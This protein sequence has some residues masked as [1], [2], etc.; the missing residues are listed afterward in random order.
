MKVKLFSNDM[1]AENLMDTIPQG[2]TVGH[3]IDE[4]G[5]QQNSLLTNSPN[6]LSP[7]QFGVNQQDSYCKTIKN[8]KCTEWMGISRWDKAIGSSVS[9][10]GVGGKPWVPWGNDE[11]NPR[12]LSLGNEMVTALVPMVENPNGVFVYS[13]KS[14]PIVAGSIAVDSDGK[15]CKTRNGKRI[16]WADSDASVF[17]DNK[18]P[19]MNNSKP[20][21]LNM[22]MAMRRQQ[23]ARIPGLNFN[24]NYLEVS[25]AVSG[26]NA[27]KL[28]LKDVVLGLNLLDG[29][30]ITPT[31]WGSIA[32]THTLA[33]VNHTKQLF[34]NLPSIISLEAN[35]KLVSE[36]NGLLALCLIHAELIEKKSG[37][38][39]AKADGKMSIEFIKNWD[40]EKD[41]I[42]DLIDNLYFS[43]SINEE[44]MPFTDHFNALEDMVNIG[45]LRFMHDSLDW[46]TSLIATT[47]EEYVAILN[48]LE[49]DTRVAQ[50]TILVRQTDDLIRQY[51]AA[52]SV[53][54]LFKLL[55]DIVFLLLRT[56]SPVVAESIQTILNIPAKIFT[57]IAGSD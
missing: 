11:G 46:R 32:K 56:L 57:E 24:G 25:P 4:N 5:N 37:I 30:P 55:S 54:L 43:N 44:L 35:K 53:R 42:Y 49:S 33:A 7:M 31:E 50:T 52:A 6:V 45:L 14:R 16:W 41:A 21:K 48:K 29:V 19:M 22:Y 47:L 1:S 2:T 28:S 9:I 15:E 51:L 34:T 13:E 26:K 3:W 20:V 17:K 27:T 8:D 18:N 23:N 38:W 39:I 10:V 40:P 36:K 12:K